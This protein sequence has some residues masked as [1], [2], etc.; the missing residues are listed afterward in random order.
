VLLSCVHDLI[1]LQAVNCIRH[2]IDFFYYATAHEHTERSL[3]KMDE[4]LKKFYTHSPI[5]EVLTGIK[6]SFP[7]CH[8][9][10]KYSSDIRSR[11]IIRGYSTNH[12]ERQHKDDAK[13]VARRTN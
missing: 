12:S 10:Q 7:K 11:G 2:F 8:A 9:M 13:K 1:P 6:L 3:L 4:T 5:F